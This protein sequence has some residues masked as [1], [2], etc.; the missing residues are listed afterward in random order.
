[1]SKLPTRK[2]GDTEVTAIGYGAMG[3]A[4]FY[5]PPMPDEDRFK[6]L[7]AL[8]ERGCTNWD[9]ADLYLDSE[10]LIGKWFKRTGKRDEI[11]LA[12]KFGFASPPPRNK[13]PDGD[14]VWAREAFQR[15]LDRLGVDHIDLWY[16]HRPDPT[17][18]IEKSVAAMAEFVEAG[19]LKYIGLS[20]VSSATLRRAH[21]VHPIAAVQVEYS[22]FSLDIEDPKVGLLKTARELGVKIIA[23]SPLGR[24]LLT[25][26]YKGPEEFPEDDFRRLVPKFSKENFPR[27]L[28]LV[29][30]LQKIG[31]RHGAT[32]G[33]VC[34]AWIL[35][36]GD[37]FIPIPGTKH[38]KYLDE[39]LGAVN[40]KLSPAELEEVRKA[41]HEA[42]VEGDRYPPAEQVW[43]FDRRRHLPPPSDD[44]GPTCFHDVFSN[45]LILENVFSFAT[46]ATIIHIGQACRSA[47]EIVLEWLPFA[48]NINRHLSRFFHDPV[49]FRS[50]QARTS[51]LIG[52]LQALKFLDR[53]AYDDPKDADP[54]LDLYVYN[55]FASD[56]AR[57]IIGSAGY[58]YGQPCHWEDPQFEK[59]L[60]DGSRRRIKVKVTF[61]PIS[62]I[63]K[64]KTTCTTNFISYE[65][66]YSLLP[67][68]TFEER[69]CL[70][71]AS[72]ARAM[73]SA[74]D[75]WEPRGW[76]IEALEPYP[77][78]PCRFLDQRHCWVLSF[79]VS[80]LASSCVPPEGPVWGPLPS[81]PVDT[82]VWKL[83]SLKQN[84]NYVGDP[85]YSVFFSN[86]LKFTYL[87]DREEILK[88][89][90]LFMEAECPTD[91]LDAKLISFLA[92][93]RQEHKSQLTDQRR[94]FSASPYW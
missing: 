30:D 61:S 53:S 52:G 38:I 47:H 78:E 44:A 87:L 29:A 46:P 59:R 12:T 80:G 51:S 88:A 85:S 32:A 49:A 9:T 28:K 62:T 2:I 69:Q 10:E 3:I 1:M 4:A 56:T 17:I 6:V 22:P 72:G 91:S 90:S 54:V 40:V 58:E 48:F 8:Y 34:L 65:K 23:Y 57:F 11:F 50:F 75:E 36:Q 84:A 45:R 31:E 82:T 43:R 79:N 63:F 7:D 68:T 55:N 66:A 21:A 15:S 81:D 92:R 24:G 37:D 60:E 93:W 42:D 83:K 77:D 19:K 35:A 26:Q 64:S 25:G 18:P 76:E 27:V 14:P 13:M 20:E 41:A 94:K 74:V 16:L 33:Q 71:I 86:Y 5:G 70:V 39:N 73:R 67:L 89:A